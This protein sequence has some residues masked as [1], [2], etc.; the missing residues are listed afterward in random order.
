M[1]KGKLIVIDGADNVGKATQV[2][3]LIERLARE[4]KKADTLD[5]P[6]YEENVFGKLLKE[7]LRGEHGDF[8]SLDPKI[9]STLYALDR[10]ESK[11]KLNGLLETNDIVVLDRYTSANMLHQGAKIENVEKRREFINWLEHIEFDIFGI[12]KPDLTI[13]LAVNFEHSDQIFNTMVKE[14]QKDPD[15]AELDRAH[16]REVAQCVEWMPSVD[17]S[18]RVLHCSGDDSLRTREEIHEDI[19]FLVSRIL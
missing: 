17:P 6:R 14:G 11:E 18:W 15:V 9:A 13:A 1:Q 12:P 5:F 10:F 2:K 4:G 3:L 7:C 19:Y 8:I 16:Q